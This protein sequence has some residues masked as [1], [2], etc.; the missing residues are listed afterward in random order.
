MPA[1]ANCQAAER[2][3]EASCLHLLD[4]FL[5]LGCTPFRLDDIKGQLIILLS[6]DV[7]GRIVYL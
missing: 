6:N 4:V 3:D 2:S 7:F 1:N 5:M